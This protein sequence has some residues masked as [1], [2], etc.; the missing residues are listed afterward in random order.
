[1]IKDTPKCVVFIKTESEKVKRENCLCSF[2][3][4]LYT[5]CEKKTV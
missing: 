2:R 5:N 1:M 4:R 3:Y